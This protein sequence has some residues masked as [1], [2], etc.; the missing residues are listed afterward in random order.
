MKKILVTGANGFIGRQ[1]LPLLKKGGYE[2]IACCLKPVNH[3]EVKWVQCNLLNLGEVSKMIRKVQPSHLLHLAW[4]TE[5]GK[6]WES[7]E[8]FQWI[9]ASLHL[10]YEFAKFGGRRLMV[11]GSCCEYDWSH[12]TGFSEERTPCNPF[13]V[14][15]RAKNMLRVIL[16][17]FC[18]LMNISFV[19]PR[20]FFLYGPFED[21]KKLVAS[22]IL[23]LLQGKTFTLQNSHY[24]RDY[25]HVE[26]VAAAI[27]SL[28]NSPLQGPCNIGSG[29]GVSLK[30]L[31]EVIQK[32]L[33]SINLLRYS[34]SEAPSP[35]KAIIADATKL[36]Q[37][38][39]FT[40]RIS[41]EQGMG[42]AVEWW[43]KQQQ[44]SEIRIS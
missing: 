44:S 38:V 5:H 6:F 41:L 24:L 33:S 26:D 32:T 13:S 31:G 18:N 20:I 16:E 30:T 25:L 14:Y 40:P 28:L 2:V 21:K 12:V 11:G 42:Y 29:Q 35:G 43:K 1:T 23:T 7:L 22:I 37:V 27:V 3:S 15:G 39:G 19:W 10:A 36:Q 4:Y 8:N 34:D 17:D 9:K